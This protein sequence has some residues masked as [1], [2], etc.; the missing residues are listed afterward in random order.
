MKIGKKIEVTGRYYKDT[1]GCKYL[2]SGDRLYTIY[3]SSIWGSV[4]VGN[5]MSC[6]GTF[7]EEMLNQVAERCDSEGTFS[8][9]I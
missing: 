9:W 4:S 1:D 2:V 5:D 7:T 3:N 6:G 8:L